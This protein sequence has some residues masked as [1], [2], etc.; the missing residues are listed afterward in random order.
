MRT[1]QHLERMAEL[2]RADH[3]SGCYPCW[4]LTELGVVEP[5]VVAYPPLER[6]LCELTQGVSVKS[7]A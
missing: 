7:I 2:G 1:D 4:L 5:A 3:R 6:G